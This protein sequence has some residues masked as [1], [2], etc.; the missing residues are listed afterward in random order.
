MIAVFIAFEYNSLATRITQK[1][2]MRSVAAESAA[3]E[4]AA[5]ASLGAMDVSA[6][7]SR[8]DPE[9]SD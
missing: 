2:H 9:D 3:L 4:N 1:R 6:I 5:L 7:A 8:A